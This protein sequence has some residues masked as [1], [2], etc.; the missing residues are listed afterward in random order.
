MFDMA[1]VVGYF[2]FAITAQSLL[3]PAQVGV[4]RDVARCPPECAPI[5]VSR[6]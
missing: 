3:F 2:A 1:F 6:L 4:H 5:L